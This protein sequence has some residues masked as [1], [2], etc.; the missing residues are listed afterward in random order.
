MELP[1]LHVLG[2]IPLWKFP[3]GS[4]QDNQCPYFVVLNTLVWSN[5]ACFPSKLNCSFNKHL[6]NA[7]CN[8]SCVR[9][10]RHSSKL[11]VPALAHTGTESTGALYSSGTNYVTW[12]LPK[13]KSIP[14]RMK[15]CLNKIKACGNLERHFKVHFRQQ[16]AHGTS[17][18]LHRARTLKG[19]I[20]SSCTS[21]CI[22]LNQSH[23]SG[24]TLP[25]VVSL[26]T[27]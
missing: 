24:V 19:T 3:L 4:T 5:P 9:C 20:P 22:S 10:W 26:A 12:L 11:T 25:A 23:Y 13:L 2:G 14:E 15:M 1:L 6:L 17:V 7:Y 16:Q 21:A 27:R 18:R 8:P